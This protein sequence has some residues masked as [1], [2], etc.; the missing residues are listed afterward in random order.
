M[1]TNNSSFALVRGKK[2]SYRDRSDTFWWSQNQKSAQASILKDICFG[3]I[4]TTRC[5]MKYSCLI[6]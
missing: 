3:K 4:N 1:H 6:L 5:H 2:C